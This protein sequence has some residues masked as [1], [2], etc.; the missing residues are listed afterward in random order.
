MRLLQGGDTA[1]KT[2]EID[3]KNRYVSVASYAQ[4]SASNIY[5]GIPSSPAAGGKPIACVPIVSA[6]IGAS[7]RCGSH[8]A[9][10]LQN[11]NWRH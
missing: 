6:S 8:A 3:G 9:E 1:I 10:R 2:V 5:R 7:L 11:V 4:N